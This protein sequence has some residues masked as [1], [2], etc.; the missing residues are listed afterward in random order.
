VGSVN[1]LRLNLCGQRSGFWGKKQNQRTGHC[2][3]SSDLLKK[4]A[5]RLVGF[6]KELVKNQPVI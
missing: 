6:M 3:A 5:Y 1:F 2:G 4:R